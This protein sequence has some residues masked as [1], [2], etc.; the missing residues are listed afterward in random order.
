MADTID[1]LPPLR[2]RALMMA[3]VLG[4]MLLAAWGLHGLGARV[5]GKLRRMASEGQSVDVTIVRLTKMGDAD[6]VEFTY[7]VNGV[8]HQWESRVPFNSRRVGEVV[9]GRYLPDDPGRARILPLDEATIHEEGAPLRTL[10]LLLLATTLFLSPIALF[11]QRA[12][13]VVGVL[14]IA[15]LVGTNFAPEI[16]TLQTRL[17]GERPL[18]LP[19]L[20]VVS[21]GE[22][23]LVGPALLIFGTA[24]FSLAQDAFRRGIA[25]SRA[26][27]MIQILIG[28]NL[29]PELRTARGRAL[30]SGLYLMT[31]MAAWIV[32]AS[33]R[34][35]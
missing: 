16:H 24:F 1:S 4:L 34:G 21:L 11:P 17:L 3:C 23:I 14:F 5:E 28:R 15:I 25:T 8:S 12:G 9:R 26:Q 6:F 30:W 29:P 27:V 32:Y 18:G 33:A 35:I 20:W 2:R 31:L 19:V 13:L 7:E 10:G 22:L